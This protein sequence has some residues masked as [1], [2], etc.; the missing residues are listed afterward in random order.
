MKKIELDAENC[1]CEIKLRVRALQTLLN[2][3]EAAYF[4]IEDPQMLV[5]YSDQAKDRQYL[6]LLLTRKLVKLA[7]ELERITQDNVK[8]C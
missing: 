7:D 3:Q 4:E 8:E 1:A 2:D 6:M 5:F